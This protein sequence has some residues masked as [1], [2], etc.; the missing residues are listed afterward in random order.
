MRD[1]A[2]TVAVL[3]GKG[4]VGKTT[5]CLNLA[6]QISLWR[7]VWLIDIDLFNRGTTSAIWNSEKDIGISV[8]Q[9]IKESTAQGSE[10]AAAV[11]WPDRWKTIATLL[12]RHAQELSYTRD[13]SVIPAARATEGR[14][15]SYILWHGTK[16]AGFAAEDFLSALLSALGHLSPGC[17]VIL[18]GHGGLDELSIGA[19]IVSD[20]TYIVNEPDLI[21]FTGSV[22][23][24]NE[25]AQ[26]CK[27]RASEP[28]IEF[29][30]NRVPPGKTISRMESEFGDVLK[31][32]SPAKEP[33]TAYFPL[34]RE[35]FSLFGDDPFV[36][37]I[38]T[39]YWFSK[40][41]KLVARHVIRTG[42]ALGR[43]QPTRLDGDREE[44]TKREDSFVR[45]ALKREFYK[46]GDQLAQ[47]WLVLFVITLG[48]F[49]VRAVSTFANDW[50][51]SGLLGYSNV[52]LSYLVVGIYLIVQSYRWWKVQR[53]HLRNARRIRTLHRRRRMGDSESAHLREHKEIQEEKKKL[54]GG[55]RAAAAVAGLL[56]F[57]AALLIPNFLDALQKA[58]QKRT[59]AEIMN[60]G[61]ALFSW[62]TDQV[63]GAAAGQSEVPED[64]K[65]V[66]LSDYPAIKDG[67]LSKVL[68]PQYLS[69]VPTADGWE[70]PYEYRLNAENVLAKHVMSI[71]SPGRDGRFA[72][73]TYT[74][75]SFDPNDY[76]QDI[77][78][79][80]GFFVRWPAPQ[81]NP[82]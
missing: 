37:E 60:T 71:R 79:A 56:L 47:A 68:V 61:V 31:T 80:D 6:R 3:S 67:D 48:T 12:E 20:I 15:A 19:A 4:G 52:L 49:L 34:E 40:K 36:S 28:R 11:S 24:Y 39:E 30:I 54:R 35:L 50:G 8:A 81:A 42:V 78:W 21:T 65:T 45:T 73:S 16:Q 1:N 13:L 77:V 9:L 27:G 22:T 43:L 63:G 72:N 14:E 38:F 64:L 58:R 59:K 51:A 26:A 33:A 32:I 41:I 66:N 23:L 44:P 55:L 18:D 29:L 69:S 2:F 25:I 10:P 70:H 7:P 46:R 5:I 74:V 57:F 82:R 76:D 17:T 62:L 75:G 53:L